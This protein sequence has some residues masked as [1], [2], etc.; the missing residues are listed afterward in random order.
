[1]ALLMGTTVILINVSYVSIFK[2]SCIINEMFSTKTIIVNC[3][4]E[5]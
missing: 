5:I 4:A 2:N 3:V 1:M